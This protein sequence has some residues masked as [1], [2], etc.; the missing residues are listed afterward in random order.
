MIQVAASQ[1]QHCELDAPMCSTE[2]IPS[3]FSIAII[4]ADQHVFASPQ[5]LF[6]GCLHIDH[7]T[8]IHAP[9]ADHEQR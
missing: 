7:Q 8:A 4:D 9:E 1:Q 3:C 2:C 6:I 5:Q